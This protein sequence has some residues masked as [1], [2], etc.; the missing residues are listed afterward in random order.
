M[1]G[2]RPFAKKKRVPVEKVR[3]QWLSIGFGVKVGSCVNNA[4]AETD[5]QLTSHRLGRCLVWASLH[6]ASLA[7][8]ISVSDVPTG[9]L[10]STIS[11]SLENACHLRIL[12][13]L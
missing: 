5:L 11:R 2:G 10:P 3:L 13:V 8:L 4:L 12:R 7:T 1:L 9:T 6:A